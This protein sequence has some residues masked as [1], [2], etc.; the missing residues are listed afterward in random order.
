MPCCALAAFI[1]GQV[2]IGLHAFKRFCFGITSEHVADNPAT[3][4]RL[5]GPPLAPARLPRRF[6]LRWTTIAL[7]EAVLIA[8][9]A[10]GFRTHFAHRQHHHAVAARSHSDSSGEKRW[11]LRTKSFTNSSAATR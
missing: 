3:E 11:P 5:N 7:V 9:G 10:F 2:M 1:L 8:G 4:W 6:G